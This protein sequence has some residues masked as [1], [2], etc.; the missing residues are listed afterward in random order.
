M[1][2]KKF[3]FIYK[4]LDSYHNSWVNMDFKKGE[5]ERFS[6]FNIL[7][8]SKEEALS[9]SY[10][11]IP[12]FYYSYSTTSL[13]LLTNY[14]INTIVHN[15]GIPLINISFSQLENQLTRNLLP[16]VKENELLAIGLSLTLCN[17]FDQ[18]KKI[19]SE[20]KKR[21]PNIPI[22][23]GGAA[24]LSEIDFYINKL[25]PL[26]DFFIQGDGEESLPLLLQCLMSNN[27]FKDIP[28]LCWKDSLNMYVKNPV[29]N[30]LDMNKFSTVRWDI[31]K[32]TSWRDDISYESSRGCSFRCSFCTYPYLS[33]RLRYKSAQS[34]YDDFYYYSKQG[35]KIIYCHDSTMLTPMNR[36]HQFID[37]MIKMPIPI[38]WTCSAQAS[39][40]QDKNFCQQLFKAG[41]RLIC[42]G[43]ESGDDIILKNMNKLVTRTQ[44]LNAIKNC[45]DAGIFCST[46]YIIGFMGE[47]VKT[48]KNTL[49]FI[50]ESQPDNYDFNPFY[51]NHTNIKLYQTNNL[52]KQ[53]RMDYDK[54][55]Q[56]INDFKINL[57]YSSNSISE[58]D[59]LLLFAGAPEKSSSS[60]WVNLIY[61]DPSYATYIRENIFPI[62]KEY[63]RSLFSHPSLSFLS[64]RNINKKN[65]SLDKFKKHQK[66]AQTLLKQQ[67]NKGLLRMG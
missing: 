59:L 4:E 61:E 46:H 9:I 23:L 20:L 67:I 56:L 17:A 2:Q 33:H 45:K 51:T 38:K 26:P 25:A 62:I 29:D 12:L 50:K 24:V 1:Q 32:D 63:E 18:I 30:Y 44:N 35:V 37:I 65:V 58:L 66:N 16:E 48:A 19:L 39:Q 11:G 31:F 64:W 5:L 53:K 13:E 49:K 55:T 60:L 28:N 14:T 10:Q 36:M 42:I 7:E 3:L 6:F 43:I 34:V 47:T 40:L 21:F 22:I 52:F 41:C 8:L 27:Q 57:V 54:A 15:A